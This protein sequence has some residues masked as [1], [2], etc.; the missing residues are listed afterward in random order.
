[1]ANTI[2][3]R[4]NIT[5][6]GNGTQPMLFAHG[7]GCDQTM[8]RFVAPAFEEN[9]KVVKFDHVGSGNSDLEA[10]DFDKYSSLQGYAD[11]LLEICEALDLNDVVFVGH[12]VSSMI[13][14]LA[15]AS[16][17]E[18]FAQLIL[19]APSP[20]YMNDGNYMG[21]FAQRDIDELIAT[22]ESNYLGWSS[23]ITPVIIGDPEKSEFSEELNTSFCAMDPKI[24]KHFAKV[25]FTS[26]NRADLKRVSTPSLIIQ[27][28]PD[29]IAPVEVGKFLHNQLKSSTYQQIATVGHCPHL[30]APNEVIS[31][32]NTFL[33]T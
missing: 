8:W 30:T 3:L 11:D 15:A 19:V 14:I 26:D 23:Y 21:G 28:H 6:T 33:K 1:M 20:R 7:Y 25:T 29:V 9:Y 31:A 27:S 5:I 2:I 10:Y 12:S 18:R 22:L 13:G 24:A 32:M 4:N 16:N 17:P